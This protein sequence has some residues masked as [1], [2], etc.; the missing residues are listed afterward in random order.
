MSRVD[1][2]REREGAST[3][4]PDPYLESAAALL[5]TL[6]QLDGF[7]ASPIAMGESEL[8]AGQIDPHAPPEGGFRLD[9]VLDLDHTL[10]HAT[11]WSHASASTGAQR[12]FLE[13]P[14]RGHYLLRARDGLRAF[15]EEARQIANLYIY[16]MGSRSYTRQVL[17]LI[18]PNKEVFTEKVLCREDGQEE[19]FP[20]SLAHVCEAEH[21]RRYMLVVDDREDAW[22]SISRGH[23][24]QIPAFRYFRS[25]GA[26]PAADPSGADSALYDVLRVLQAVHADIHE[27]RHPHVPSAL[28]ARRR[29][30]LHGQH[31]V[32]SGGLLNDA[33]LNQKRSAYWRLAEVFGATCHLRM[34]EQVTHVVSRSANTNTVGKALETPRIFAVSP[35]WL[36][37]S[38]S[39]WHRQSE[40][41]YQY[42]LATTSP[43]NLDIRPADIKA[44]V[45]R[46]LRV[47]P[48]T[49]TKGERLQ[50]LIKYVVPHEHKEHA[51]LLLAKY[52]QESGEEV[53][54]KALEELKQLAGVEALKTVLQACELTP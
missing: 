35:L 1:R 20:K 23:V 21:R 44:M 12:F 53:R 16:T 15:L 48:P 32:F 24:L 34:N 52:E 43:R 29:A 31:L 28:L 11:E 2:K 14:R 17:S 8:E 9:L 22:D 39:R 6:P 13:G 46:V 41:P 5:P 10:V 36:I 40:E 3:T 38:C 45:D 50:V 25:D 49:L 54:R 27:G 42:S 7:G 51:N 37:H 4:S 19:I 18:D 33:P 30:V 47:L 26:A